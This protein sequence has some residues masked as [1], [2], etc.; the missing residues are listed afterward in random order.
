MR[1]HLDGIMVGSGTALADDPRL[2]ARDVELPGGQPTRV[3]VDGSLRVPTTAR[4]FHQDGEVLVAMA[5]GAEDAKDARRACG[6]TILELDDGSGKVDLGALLDALGSHAPEPITGLLVE[7]GSGLATA[8]LEADL[9]DR[10]HLFIA[11]TVMGGDGLPAIG[12]LGVQ[13]PDEAPRFEVLHLN[14]LGDDLE[15]VLTRSA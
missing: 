6:A 13:H 2:T 7:G 11:P 3:L 10:L 9:V 12:S 4:L 1:A 14:S 15:L 5:A 8:L